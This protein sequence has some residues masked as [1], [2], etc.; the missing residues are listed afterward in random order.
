MSKA[1]CQ[2]SAL[3]EAQIVRFEEWSD[4]LEGFDRFVEL[5]RSAIAADLSAFVCIKKDWADG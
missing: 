4:G 3:R 2:V 1:E 5:R